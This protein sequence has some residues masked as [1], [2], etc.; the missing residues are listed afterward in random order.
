MSGENRSNRDRHRQTRKTERDRDQTNNT[1]QAFSNHATSSPSQRRSNAA[2]L[3]ARNGIVNNL[4]AD[5]YQRSRG[6]NRDYFGS[7]FAARKRSP[8]ASRDRVMSSTSSLRRSSPPQSEG[9][10]RGGAG[11][12]GVGGAGDVTTAGVSGTGA[13]G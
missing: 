12:S 8:A 3:P 5:Q 1:N 6:S 10:G 9:L 7:I 2:S 13:G 4:S 11:G